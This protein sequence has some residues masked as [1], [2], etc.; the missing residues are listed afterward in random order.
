MSPRRSSVS[1]PSTGRSTATASRGHQASMSAAPGASIVPSRFASSRLPSHACR[2]ASSWASR[3]FGAG[4]RAIARA[5]AGTSDARRSSV[6]AAFIAPTTRAGETF[7]FGN[8]R[9]RSCTRWTEP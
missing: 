5:S 4:A 8:A 7:P 3:A 1:G 9:F 6:A 2:S